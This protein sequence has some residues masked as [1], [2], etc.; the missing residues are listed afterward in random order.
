MFYLYVNKYVA[1]NSRLWKIFFSLQTIKISYFQRK[2][3]LSGF[4][5]YPD[6]LPSHLIRISVVL[7]YLVSVLLQIQSFD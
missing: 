5:A 6:V 2:I 1:Y 4:S 3:Q 7:L